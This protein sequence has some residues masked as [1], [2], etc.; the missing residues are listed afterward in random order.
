ML[1]SITRSSFFRGRC[2]FFGTEYGARDFWGV[3]D[4]G[5]GVFLLGK[6][7]LVGFLGKIGISAKRAEGRGDF[8][9]TL[10]NDG[11]EGPIFWWRREPKNLRGGANFNLSLPPLKPKPNQ[12]SI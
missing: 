9:E 7:P 3:S 4:L 6:G 12:I 11:G 8:L 1:K 10:R 2:D 5:E